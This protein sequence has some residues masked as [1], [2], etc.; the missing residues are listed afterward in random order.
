MDRT[1]GNMSDS[2]LGSGNE[3]SGGNGFPAG[4]AGPIGFDQIAQGPTFY[5]TLNVEPNATK[6]AIREA[7][8]RLK[9]TFGSGNAALYSLMSEEESRA[10]I[11]LIDEAYRVLN[12]ETRRA[13]YDR[14]LGLDWE[15]RNARLSGIPG[16][17]RIAIADEHFANDQ[18]A[19]GLS[20]D[21]STRSSQVIQTTRST[22][23]IV[24]TTADNARNE[25][26]QARVTALIAEGDP[27][28]GDLYRRIREAIG[29]SE[30]EM[31]ERTKVSVE[32][33]RAI[34]SNRFE[35]LPQSV[36][37]KGFLRSYFKYLAVPDGEKFVPAYAA[38]LEAWQQSRKN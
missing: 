28:D 19:N 14:S 11:A 34:E 22:L 18:D 33:M 9:N 27:G 31:Q 29:V 35:R 10:N 32:Y 21:Q 3:A 8:L 37:V 36:Y 20:L 30:H 13:E 6:M 26:M 38:R 4:S 15:H 2:H 12:D 23:A 24:K 16:A 25:A 7:Y 1:L 5:E 17:Q